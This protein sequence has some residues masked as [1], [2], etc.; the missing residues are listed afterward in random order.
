MNVLASGAAPKNLLGGSECFPNPN[1]HFVYPLKLKPRSAAIYIYIYIYIYIDLQGASSIFLGV[2]K[3][4]EH[5]L[6]K[7]LT[8]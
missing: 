2:R 1:F 8:L 4:I 6:T 5:L 7:L 3:P